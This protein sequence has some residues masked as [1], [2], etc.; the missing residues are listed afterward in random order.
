MARAEVECRLTTTGPDRA[1]SSLLAARHEY[2]TELGQAEFVRPSKER[3][4]LHVV[5]IEFHRLVGRDQTAIRP[6][7]DQSIPQL[8]APSTRRSELEDLAILRARVP[9]AAVAVSKMGNAV[10]F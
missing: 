2:G 5:I 7:S 3:A 9:I 4:K 6:T 8:H 10:E 1:P